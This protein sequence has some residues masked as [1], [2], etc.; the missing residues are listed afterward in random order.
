[1]DKEIEQ[2]EHLDRDDFEIKLGDYNTLKVVKE[3]DFGVY[4]DGGKDGEI[5]MPKNMSLKV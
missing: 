4:L 1:M 3:V 2:D 5:L